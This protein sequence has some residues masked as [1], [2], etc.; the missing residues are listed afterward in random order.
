[1]LF[2][3]NFMTWLGSSLGGLC[4]VKKFDVENLCDV[5]NRQH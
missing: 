3:G 5:E 1:M 4:D 2:T